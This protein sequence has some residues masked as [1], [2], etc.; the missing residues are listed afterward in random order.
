MNTI[1]IEVF[2]NNYMLTRFGMLNTYHIR[3]VLIDFAKKISIDN[4][5][6]E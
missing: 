1:Y 5:L 4:L 2:I 3:L 6:I